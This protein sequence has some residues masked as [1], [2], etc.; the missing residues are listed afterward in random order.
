MI[1][2]PLFSPII[3]CAFHI[4]M[5]SIKTKPSGKSFLSIVTLSVK[6]IGIETKIA[7]STCKPIKW[8]GL[9]ASIGVIEAPH[10]GGNWAVTWNGNQVRIYA[11]K[12]EKEQYVDVT[13]SLSTDEMIAF[14]KCLVEWKAQIDKINPFSES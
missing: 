4:E 14:K 5:I 7:L 10:C 13:M 12:Y 2:C 9:E 8:V 11:S 6:R 3:L 1:P